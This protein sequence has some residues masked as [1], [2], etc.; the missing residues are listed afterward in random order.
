MFILSRGEC[1]CGRLLYQKMAA[2]CCSAV[3][4]GQSGVLTGVLIESVLFGSSQRG[5]IQPCSAV[6]ALASESSMCLSDFKNASDS[7]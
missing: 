3:T 1:R 7:I 5:G 2:R 4:M 6:L